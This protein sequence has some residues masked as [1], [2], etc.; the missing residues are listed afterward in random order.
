MRIA[1]SPNTP[2][3]PVLYFLHLT[4]YKPT[5]AVYVGIHASRDINF[6]TEQSHDPFIGGGDKMRALKGSRDQFEVKTL[7]VGTYKDCLARFKT[8]PINYDH[9][10]CLNT[11]EG[12]PAGVPKALSTGKP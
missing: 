5:G 11:K 12:A 8:L 4:T 7:L 2:Q 10:L 6:G 3:P 9:P 1:P